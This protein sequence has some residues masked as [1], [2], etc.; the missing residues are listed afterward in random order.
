MSDI[1]PV[2][3][4][5]SFLLSQI[6]HLSATRFTERIAEAG[7]L[8]RPYG[9][10]VQLAAGGGRTQQQLADAMGVHRNAMV[11]LVDELEAKGLVERRRHP[12]DRRAYAVHLTTVAEDVLGGLAPV[13]DTHDRELCAGLDEE[14]RA[15]LVG[16]LSKLALSLELIPGV[17]PGY[18]L[19]SEPDRPVG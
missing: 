9:L 14:E 8:P 18:H 11:G 16:L 17:H 6:G 2:W 19:K 12:A 1:P 7:L 5:P 3:N 13:M 10:L 15:A 4:R